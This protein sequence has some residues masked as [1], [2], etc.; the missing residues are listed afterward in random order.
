MIFHF[1]KGS[2]QIGRKKIDHDHYFLI[3]YYKLSLIITSMKYE[4]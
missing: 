4:K 2:F 3:T 1:V